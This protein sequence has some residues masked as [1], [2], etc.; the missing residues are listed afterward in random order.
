[1]GRFAYL[2]YL[3]GLVI[4]RVEVVFRSEIVFV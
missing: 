1:M 2:V 4:F 3:D